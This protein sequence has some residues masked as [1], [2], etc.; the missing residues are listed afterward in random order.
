MPSCNK[1]IEGPIRWR[2]FPLT[3]S[4]AYWASSSLEAGTDRVRSNRHWSSGLG[5][6]GAGSSLGTSIFYVGVV[7]LGVRTHALKAGLFLYETGWGASCGFKI[8]AETL[9]RSVLHAPGPATALV[10]G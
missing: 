1:R 6:F 10:K 9:A 4:K 7:V 3:A 2:S 5:R 8:A